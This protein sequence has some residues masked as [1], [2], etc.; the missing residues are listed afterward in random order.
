LLGIL[1]T[2]GFNLVVFKLKALWYPTGSSAGI[3][4]IFYGTALVIALVATLLADRRHPFHRIEVGIG[5]LAGLASG[6]GILLTMASLSLPSVVAFPVNQGVALLGGVLL[7]AIIYHERFTP[8]KLTGLA[9]GAI[10]LLLGGLR[11]QLTTM[12]HLPR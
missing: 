8:A 7:T 3:T 11:E 5:M 10:V 12:I 9:L 2:N 4:A 6:T 1:G